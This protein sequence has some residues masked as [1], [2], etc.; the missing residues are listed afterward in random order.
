MTTYEIYPYIVGDCT[1]CNGVLWYYGEDAPKR[2]RWWD[3]ALIC[4]HRVKWFE[5][6]KDFEEEYKEVM[7]MT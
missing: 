1:I 4:D 3:E 7:K 2:F 5:L 6:S